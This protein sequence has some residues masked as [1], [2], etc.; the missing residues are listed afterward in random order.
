MI[1]IHVERGRGDRGVASKN[2]EAKLN[3]IEANN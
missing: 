1:E 2:E 3:A